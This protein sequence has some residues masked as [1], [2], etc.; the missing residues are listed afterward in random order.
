MTPGALDTFEMDYLMACLERHKAGDWGDLCAEDKAA[1]EEDLKTGGRLFSNYKQG[2]GK[3]APALYIITE[4]DRSVT[5]LLLPDEYLVLF[6]GREGMLS[7][8][9]VLARKVAE[10]LTYGWLVKVKR[11]WLATVNEEGELKGKFDKLRAFVGHLAEQVRFQYQGLHTRHPFMTPGRAL[12]AAI[13]EVQKKLTALESKHDFAWMDKVMAEKAW[14]AFRDDLHEIEGVSAG[15]LIREMGGTEAFWK[16]YPEDKVLADAYDKARGFFWAMTEKPEKFFGPATTAFEKVMKLLY[17]DAKDLA[18]ARAKG[19]EIPDESM[20]KEFDL[21][22]LKIVIADPNVTPYEAQQY[23]RGADQAYALLGRKKFLA[24]WRGVVFIESMEARQFTEEMTA[25]YA[26]LGYKDMRAS[27]GTYHD[28][29]DAVVLTVAPGKHFVET[30]VHELGHRYWFKFMKSEQR[31]RFNALIQTN[32][33]EQTRAYP[34]GWMEEGTPG[35]DLTGLLEAFRGAFKDMAEDVSKMTSDA[36]PWLRA[37]LISRKFGARFDDLLADAPKELQTEALDVLNPLFSALDGFDLF[38]DEEKAAL[39]KK[40]VQQF[41]HDWWANDLP[42]AKR[43]F[44][45][46]VAQALASSG[47]VKPV[48]PVS[49]YGQSSIEEAF[50]EAWEHYVLERDMSRDQLESFRSVLARRFRLRPR[51][52]ALRAALGV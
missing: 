34:S 15:K 30:L 4:A 28:G 31:A 48:A 10:D 27:A 46:L 42:T 37:H 14:Q 45:R 25:A 43:A 33:S 47:K 36:K 16:K 6:S 13:A 1:N 29:K 2:A 40:D 11:G 17:A 26:R 12:D 9:R 51:V 8:A 20:A 44:E 22:G 18:E 19:L 3:G 41:V 50:A 32:P 52:R 24:P 38:T 35:F 7:P 5:T 23:L 39:T 21:H 49:D